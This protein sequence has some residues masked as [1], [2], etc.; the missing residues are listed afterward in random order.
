MRGLRVEPF[1]TS[2]DLKVSGIQI[3]NIIGYKEE[4]DN[5]NYVE[6]EEFNEDGING[7]K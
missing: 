1:L 2:V 6:Y 4:E 3:D 7:F 5:E